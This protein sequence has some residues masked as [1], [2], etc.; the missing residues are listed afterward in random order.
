MVD[1]QFINNDTQILFQKMLW[2][3]AEIVLAKC[4]CFEVNV[5][6]NSVTA[7]ICITSRKAMYEFIKFSYRTFSEAEHEKPRR[8]AFF[9]RLDVIYGGYNFQALEAMTN[10]L[11]YLDK[12]FNHQKDSLQ[13]AFYKQNNFLAFE[14]GLGKTITSASISRMHAIS[15]TVIFCPSAVKWNWFDDLRKFG[16]N[17]LYFTLLDSARRRTIN[18][19]QERFVICNYDIIENFESHICGQEVGHFIFDEAQKLKNHLSGRSKKVRKILEKFPNARRTFL[20]GTPISNRVNDIFN[21]LKMTDHELGHNHAKFLEQFTVRTSGRGGER[22]TGGKNL[23]DLHIKLSN[24]MIRRT[25]AECLDLPAKT[26]LNYKYEMD[27]YRGEY[28]AIIKEMLKQNNV[29]ALTGNIHSLNIVTSKAKKAG[30]IELAETIIEDGRKVVI[31][32]GYKQPLNDLEEHFRGRCVKIDGSVDSFMRNEHVK[33]FIADPNCV[34]FLGNWDAAG[35]GINLV[36]ASDIIVQNFPLTPDKLWQGID[37]L[38]RIG[39]VNSVNIHLTFGENSVD[40]HLWALLQDKEQD[41]NAVIDQGKETL[42]RENMVEILIKKLLNKDDIVF[43]NPFSKARGKDPGETVIE[44]AKEEVVTAPPGY[45]V[46]FGNQETPIELPPT[47][48]FKPEGGIPT[49]TNLEPGPTAENTAY[50]QKPLSVKGPRYHLM[51]HA[52]SNSLFI[53]NEEEL[54]SFVAGDDT[55]TVVTWSDERAE[56]CVKIGR[57]LRVQKGYTFEN[58]FTF[59]KNPEPFRVST[60]EEKKSNFLPSPPSFTEITRESPDIEED[61]PPA[62]L[63][64]SGYGYLPPPKFL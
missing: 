19:F 61:L 59:T 1:I 24:F 25:K 16:F 21:Y 36:N 31:F 7:T 34:V 20:S 9:E 22:V 56:Q 8:D 17:E 42:M 54:E 51:F 57:H 13:E 6:T 48:P 23:Q 44:A 64:E 53:L 55:E 12:F 62:P 52:E 35:V 49:F 39:Q 27:D 47:V 32:G 15:R 37:R 40:E 2:N 11:P 29:S 45:I 10:R 46:S 38:H 43:Q 14:M 26:Y 33:Q 18:A 5:D 60:N 3:E 58:E 41:I 63:H 4:F 30:I 28:D 50:N